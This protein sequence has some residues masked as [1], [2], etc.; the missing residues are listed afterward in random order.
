MRHS[1]GDVPAALAAWEPE[2]LALGRKLVALVQDMG[3][4]S[5]V[6]GTCTP[7]DPNL[8]F[9]LYGPGR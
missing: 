1:R 8:L 9:G 7:G 3:H 5:Q 2:Q 6:S 4:R